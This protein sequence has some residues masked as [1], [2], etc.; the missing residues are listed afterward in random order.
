M[1]P[2]RQKPAPQEKDQYTYD[3]MMAR[4]RHQKSGGGSRRV[5]IEG[6]DGSV[7]VKKRKRRSQQPK[8]AKAERVGKLKV[9]LLLVA[10]PLV[11]L[12]IGTYLLLN[13]RYQSDGFRNDISER[14]SELIGAKTELAPFVFKGL[15]ANTR[16]LFV[17][18]GSGAFLQSAELTSLQGDLTPGSLFSSSWNLKRLD[19]LHG[20]IRFQ[21]PRRSFA[22]VAKPQSR[23][24]LVGAGLGF[25]SRPESFDINLFRVGNTKFVWTNGRKDFTFINEATVTSRSLG[26]LTTFQIADAKLNIQGWPEFHIEWAKLEM[27]KD[28]IQIN[29]ALLK[30]DFIGRL[31]GEASLKGVIDL[32]DGARGDLVC[33]FDAMPAASLIDKAWSG[34]IEGDVDATLN[35]RTDFAKL[36][37]TNVSGP[38]WVRNGSFGDV[39]PVKRLAAF[40]AEPRMSRIQFHSIK[41]HIT[42]QDGVRSVK[43]LEAIAPDFV[44]VSGSYTIQPDGILDGTLEVSISDKILAQVPGGKPKFFGATDAKNGM[45]STTVKVG[46]TSSAP[47]DDLTPRIEAA[48]EQYKIDTAAPPASAYPTIPLAPGA[49]KSSQPTGAKKA[50]EDAFNQLVEP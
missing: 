34:K 35:F 10:V 41:G 8:K 20:T 5:K 16:S 19:A 47:T 4:L 46:G 39:T 13:V 33:Q 23:M 6:A 27:G 14:S 31:G 25:S 26:K 42:M 43:D 9:R 24:N 37:S 11:L 40:L 48:I 1:D 45:S 28:R 49:K 50:A 30:H 15:T 18:P 12:I 7:E 44:Q 17:E 21:A 32:T 38:F 22:S 36:G 29:D 3:E 2:R